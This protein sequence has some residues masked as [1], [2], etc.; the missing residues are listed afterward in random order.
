MNDQKTKERAE[1]EEGVKNGSVKVDYSMPRTRQEAKSSLDY[2]SCRLLAR[3]IGGSSLMYE[4]L[5]VISSIDQKSFIAIMV[6]I[7]F[8]VRR[9]NVSSDESRQTGICPEITI[10]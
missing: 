2:N 7:D 3:I 1:F 10:F 9:A 5:P 4:S 8:Q 6:G